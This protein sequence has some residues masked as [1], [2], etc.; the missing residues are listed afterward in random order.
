MPHDA[1]TVI[2]ERAA[3]GGWLLLPWEGQKATG[4]TH[5]APTCVASQAVDSESGEVVD[6]TTL[7]KPAGWHPSASGR[8][9]TIAMFHANYT[10]A[11]LHFHRC[12]DLVSEVLG[13]ESGHMQVTWRCVRSLLGQLLGVTQSLT[14]SQCWPFW[15]HTNAFSSGGGLSKHR[16]RGHEG[17]LER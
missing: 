6:E 12:S 13:S 17:L 8:L 15:P 1:R 5:L 10:P 16:M 2:P 3:V 11:R 9:R 4:I 14:V 7:R